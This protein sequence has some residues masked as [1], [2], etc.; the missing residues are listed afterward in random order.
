MRCFAP[1]PKKENGI[2]VPK[3]QE[4]ANSTQTKVKRWLEG[5]LAISRNRDRPAR[6]QHPTSDS[7]VRV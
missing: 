7:C 2:A 3:S 5:R 6:S 1:W 4:F